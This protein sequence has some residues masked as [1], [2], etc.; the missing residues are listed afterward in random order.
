MVASLDLQHGSLPVFDASRLVFVGM[1]VFAAFTRHFPIECAERLFEAR[2]S[3]Q[4]ASRNLA[5]VHYSLPMIVAM[6]YFRDCRIALPV[7]HFMLRR[8]HFRRAKN[9]TWEEITH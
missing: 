6:L 5:A 2:G 7:V 1:S 9:L 4:I 8:Q 3:W